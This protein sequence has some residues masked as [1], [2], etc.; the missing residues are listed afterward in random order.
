MGTG[1]PDWQG[2]SQWVGPVITGGVLAAITSTLTGITSGVAG[3]YQCLMIECGQSLSDIHV[4]VSWTEASPFGAIGYQDDYYFQTGQN[5]RIVTPVRGTGFAISA[6]SKNATDTLTFVVRG[7]NQPPEFTQ[8]AF[9]GFALNVF[10]GTVPG[11]G[12][13]TQPI[14]P[15]EGPVSVAITPSSQ[16]FDAT[17]F[18]Y[19]HTGT[20]VA[21]IAL[22]PSSVDSANGYHELRDEINLPRYIN[23]L[24]TGNASATAFTYNATVIRRQP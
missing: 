17:V 14:S 20:V 18:C 8:Q 24:V 6:Q 23:K 10:G 3:N 7:T 5:V 4:R 2:Y 16:N 19:D 21:K 1:A 12:T 13:D 22:A 11:S 9:A 15:C